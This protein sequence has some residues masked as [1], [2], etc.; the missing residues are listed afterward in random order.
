MT[1]RV[2]L[3]AAV[4]LAA[5]FLAAQSP[6]KSGINLPNIDTTVRPQDD[7]FRYANGRWLATAHI[8]RP[9]GHL[10][11]FYDAFALTP[12]DPAVS[13]TSDARTR[14]V[15]TACRLPPPPPPSASRTHR[16]PDNHSLVTA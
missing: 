10:A 8:P 15:I 13:A 11:A 2:A 5:P 7:L 6:V 4:V 9:V 16:W 3:V 14:L 1:I 12:W